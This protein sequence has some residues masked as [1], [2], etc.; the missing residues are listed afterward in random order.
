MDGW[1]DACRVHLF[2]ICL[3]DC[4]VKC[5]LTGWMD[6]CR[7]QHFC[8]R[9]NASISVMLYDVFFLLRALLNNN[10]PIERPNNQDIEAYM[11]V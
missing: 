7:V 6:A 2:K 4:W 10:A 1:M 8:I 11:H 3:S 9:H 5:W